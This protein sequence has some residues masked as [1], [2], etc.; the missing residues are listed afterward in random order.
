MKRNAE[1]K[2]NTTI[3][4]KWYTRLCPNGYVAISW[5]QHIKTK[6][7]ARTAPPA[8]MSEFLL[9]CHWRASHF[10][11]VVICSLALLLLYYYFY[12]FAYCLAFDF[13]HT[14]SKFCAT[15]RQF[16][17][18]TWL[19]RSLI[20]RVH[21]IQHTYVQFVHLWVLNLDSI[22]CKNRLLRQATGVVINAQLTWLL[23]FRRLP[24]MELSGSTPKLD[25]N[26]SIYYCFPL[27]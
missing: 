19:N 22:N 4:A 24:K 14:L 18:K 27:Y 13:A 26:I 8:T 15:D 7:S 21:T 2:Q 11:A 6:S 1:A 10:F 16:V 3:K 25:Q 20:Q 17:G 9:P 12:S 23:C 5:E